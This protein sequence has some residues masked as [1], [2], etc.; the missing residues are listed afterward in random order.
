MQQQSPLDQNQ[1][2]QVSQAGSGAAELDPQILSLRQGIL[3]I[4]TDPKNRL[5]AIQALIDLS[6]RDSGVSQVLQDAF[7]A[8]HLSTRERL[9][10]GRHFLENSLDTSG[11]QLIL[12]N[13]SGHEDV[14]VR[15]G[16]L[17]CMQDRTEEVFVNARLQALLENE[18]AVKFA[19]ASATVYRVGSALMQRR[20]DPSCLREAV[21]LSRFAAQIDLGGIP[22]IDVGLEAVLKSVLFP[23]LRNF[24]VPDSSRDLSPEQ[25]LERMSSKEMLENVKGASEFFSRKALMTYIAMP[26]DEPH[27]VISREFRA[28][29]AALRQE[30]IKA[31]LT[32]GASDNPPINLANL[33]MPF[34]D[35]LREVISQVELDSKEFK[36]IFLMLRRE[37]PRIEFMGVR[38]S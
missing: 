9:V 27:L 13:L 26:S 25:R 33:P 10:I 23:T 6:A 14:R 20:T 4:T 38:N 28:G 2:R 35:A 18:P 11:R 19:A 17:A 37:K 3:D 30:I 8:S 34:V 32:V 15:L 31:Y 16:C 1:P 36:S 7:L 12:R 5:T 29:P 21:A 24:L 22:A